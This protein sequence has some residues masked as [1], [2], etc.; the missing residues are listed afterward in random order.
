[1]NGVA[2]CKKYNDGGDICGDAD[3]PSDLDEIPLLEIEAV[4]VSTK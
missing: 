4:S 3:S 1:M 2:M